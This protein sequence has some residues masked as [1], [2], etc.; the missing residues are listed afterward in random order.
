MRALF[1]GKFQ[2]FHNGH[3]EVIK[4]IDAETII[5]AVCIGEHSEYDFE[6]NTMIEDALKDESITNCLFYYIYDINDLEH[7]VAYVVKELPFFDYV[8][9]NNDETIALFEDKGIL[10]IRTHDERFEGISGTKIRKMI[11]NG[12][13]VEHLVPKAILKY[14]KGGKN[15]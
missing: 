13:S 5:I 7:W 10:T 14:L 2:P 8:V 4:S 1:I 9:S 6:H 3:L 12:E 15:D 11:K